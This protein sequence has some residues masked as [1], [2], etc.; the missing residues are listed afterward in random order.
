MVHV[1]SLPH[2]ALVRNTLFSLVGHHGKHSS[3]LEQFSFPSPSGKSDDHRSRYQKLFLFDG[4]MLWRVLPRLSHRVHLRLCCIWSLSVLGL[5]T[6]ASNN[7]QIGQKK[8]PNVRDNDVLVLALICSVR[9]DEAEHSGFANP[10]L[11]LIDVS[12]PT[13][14]NH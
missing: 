13:T 9:K 1:S 3:S 5:G 12:E 10:T 11:S 8:R 4:T 14:F 6:N 2:T 7:T